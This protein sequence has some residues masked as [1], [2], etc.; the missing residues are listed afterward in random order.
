MRTNLREEQLVPDMDITAL[1]TY[2]VLAQL[3]MDRGKFLAGND[4]QVVAFLP[5]FWGRR[6]HSMMYD[7]L[8]VDFGGHPAPGLYPNLENLS[9]FR[10]RNGSRCAYRMKHTL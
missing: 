3:Y 4:Q 9:V 2:R 1:A 6:R 7:Y 5:C 10:Q 8:A